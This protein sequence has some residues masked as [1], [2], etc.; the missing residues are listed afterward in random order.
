[1]PL[2]TCAHACSTR[3]QQCTFAAVAGAWIFM[4]M[5]GRCSG[6]TSPQAIRH[7]ATAAGVRL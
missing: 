1:M 7:R 6:S 3:C 4:S 5:G 2:S